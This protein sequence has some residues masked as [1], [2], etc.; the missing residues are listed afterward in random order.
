MVV[1][2]T[3]RKWCPP[4]VVWRSDGGGGGDRGVVSSVAV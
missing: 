1:W 4:G 2:E 3:L